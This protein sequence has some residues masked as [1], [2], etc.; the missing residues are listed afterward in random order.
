MLPYLIFSN[1]KLFTV[2][3]AFS[4]INNRVLSKSLQDIPPCL[5]KVRITQT[6]ASVMIWA[7]VLSEGKSPLNFVAKGIKINK[8]VYINEILKDGL[9]P[10][11]RGMYPNANST[12]QQDGATSH[13]ANLTQQ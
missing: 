9:M 13:M 2:K 7:A 11:T 1:E 10:L 5:K 3:A 8:E 12:F 6:S 4:H